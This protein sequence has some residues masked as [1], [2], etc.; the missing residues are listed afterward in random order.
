MYYIH[1]MT[2]AKSEAAHLAGHC[3]ATAFGLQAVAVGSR[4][5]RNEERETKTD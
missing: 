3:A 4:E 5:R 2:H 1:C